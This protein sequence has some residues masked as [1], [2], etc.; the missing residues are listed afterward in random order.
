MGALLFVI[1]IVLGVGLA[2]A[3][4]LVWGKRASRCEDLDA[5]ACRRLDGTEGASAALGGERPA[6]RERSPKRRAP[7]RP[8]AIRG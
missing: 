1:P 5:A 4:V 3:F 8:A 7:A 6:M 2:A